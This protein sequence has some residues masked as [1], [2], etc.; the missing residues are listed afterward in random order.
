MQDHSCWLTPDISL[1]S[2]TVSD[3]E[4]DIGSLPSGPRDNRHSSITASSIGLAWLDVAVPPG[5]RA[6]RERYKGV[7]MGQ[8]KL[9]SAAKLSRSFGTKEPV[10]LSENCTK[11]G[12]KE[13]EHIYDVQELG[14]CSGL[15]LS[16]SNIE[17]C[18]E[19]DL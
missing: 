6:S 12:N 8:G 16:L 1:D 17:I 5:C 10:H 7:L 18:L 15:A 13:S 14:I 4:H 2:P 9:L 19:E 11:R 3:L